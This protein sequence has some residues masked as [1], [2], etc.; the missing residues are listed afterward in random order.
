[1]VFELW[2]I[3]ILPE[4]NHR[5]L[6]DNRTH[7]GMSYDDRLSVNQRLM[8]RELQLAHRLMPPGFRP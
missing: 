8:L 2:E 4:D 7:K 3:I 6:F 1:M 5:T